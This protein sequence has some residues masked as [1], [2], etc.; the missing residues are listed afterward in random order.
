[1]DSKR[2]GDREHLVCYQCTSKSLHICHHSN[3][4][5]FREGLADFSNDLILKI[6]HHNLNGL[7]NNAKHIFGRVKFSRVYNCKYFESVT[8]F[9]SPLGLSQSGMGGTKGSSQPPFQTSISSALSQS[10]MGSATDAQKG[11]G[12]FGL[13]NKTTSNTSGHSPFKTNDSYSAGPGIHSMDYS[14]GIRKRIGCMCLQWEG[15]EGGVRRMK[16]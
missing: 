10:G 9:F 3:T 7:S 15:G 13:D 11:S 16:R 14:T 8:V 4:V 1:M 2:E 6:D 12:L 5:F